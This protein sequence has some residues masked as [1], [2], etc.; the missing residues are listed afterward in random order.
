MTDAGRNRAILC[1]LADGACFAVAAAL[2]KATRS[3]GIPVVEMVVFRSAVIAAAMMA[4]LALQGGVLAAL[5]TRRWLGHAMRI[6]LGFAA[7][8]S[9][10]YGYVRLP[11]AS[12]TALNFAMPLFLTVLSVPLLGERVG[13]RRWAAVLAGFAGVLV[14]VRPWQAVAAGLPLVA[15]AVVMGGVVAWAL[16][17]ITIRRLGAAGEGNATIVLLY[18]LGTLVLSA[19]LAVPVWVAPSPRIAALLVAAGLATAAAQWLMTEAYRGGE[20][21][22]V[23][24]FEYGAI[25]PASLLGALFWGE[26]PDG[27]TI[28]GVA[29]LVAAGVYIWRREN[30]LA[31]TRR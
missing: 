27:W 20:A 28:A 4:A 5:R 22:S 12:V 30:A 7:M 26:W 13:W 21:T 6:V 11:L 23:A 17:T 15:V 10:Y 25:I 18:S 3:A 16:T 31:R 9:S 24:P 19:G 14:I 2:I 1:V 29:I 8:A